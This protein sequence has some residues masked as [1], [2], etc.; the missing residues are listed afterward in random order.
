MGAITRAAANNFTTSGVILPGAIN[1]TTVASI[2]Q[3]TQVAGKTQTLIQSQTASSSSAINFTTGIDNSYDIYKFEFINLHP[4]TDNVQFFHGASTDGGSNYNLAPIL[5]FFEAEN[6]E[7]SEGATLN[8]ITSHD[9]D[10]NSDNSAKMTY[11][12][13]NDSDQSISG[14]MWLFGPSD[15]TFTKAFMTSISCTHRSNY[16]KN[17]YTCGYYNTTSDI[18]AMQFSLSSGNIDAGKIKLYG[19]QG[20]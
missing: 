17:S 5:T 3:L 7:G 4:A 16:I 14:E 9:N 6:G 15:T 8:Y 11:N 2:S 1:N 12:I 20:S 10:T 18:D 13:G 19:I